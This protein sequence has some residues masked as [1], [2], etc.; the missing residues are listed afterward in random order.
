[1]ED[2]EGK[3]DMNIIFVQHEILETNIALENRKKGPCEVLVQVCT[4]MKRPYK[5]YQRA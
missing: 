5:Y 2:W 4:A 1:M 3:G